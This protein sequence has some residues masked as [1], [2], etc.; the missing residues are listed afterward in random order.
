MSTPSSLEDAECL[1]HEPPAL[2]Q[3]VWKVA[4]GEE[5]EQRWAWVVV[6]LRDEP[7]N[8]MKLYRDWDDRWRKRVAEILRARALQKEPVEEK[9]E[10]DYGFDNDK[11]ARDGR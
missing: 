9:R 7:M 5:V 11:A 2:L 4:K 1:A 6:L 10:A 8:F 3:A